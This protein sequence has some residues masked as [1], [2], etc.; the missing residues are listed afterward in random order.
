MYLRSTSGR[1]SANNLRQVDRLEAITTIG[2][3]ELDNVS[4][5]E[6]NAQSVSGR[7]DI[8]EARVSDTIPRSDTRLST[9][10][11]T[12]NVEIIG[13][14]DDFSYEIRTTSGR[15]R[16]DGTRPPYVASRTDRVNTINIRTVSGSITLNFTQ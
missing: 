5:A 9:T 10:S 8:S 1:I 4:W 3:I 7:I 12:V 14:R 15:T 16:V 13:D 6:L 11:G 2:R